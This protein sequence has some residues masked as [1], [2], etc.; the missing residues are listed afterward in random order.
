MD[1]ERF[2]GE[3]LREPTWPEIKSFNFSASIN[4][5]SNYDASN[6]EI[7]WLARIMC[8]YRCFDLYRASHPFRTHS[9]CTCLFNI[10][11]QKFSITAVLF[12]EC[13]NKKNRSAMTHLWFCRFVPYA[14]P[15]LPN[16]TRRTRSPAYMVSWLGLAETKSWTTYIIFSLMGGGGGAG[17]A[18][19]ACGGGGAGGAGV[20]F[21][22]V[23]GFIT[24]SCW[25]GMTFV[26]DGS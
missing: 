20:C 14:H 21:G 12:I 24:I 10:L 5:R 1:W 19:A 15:W 23:A 13:I 16:L 22:D 4:Y 7:K 17:G 25:P 3:S 6:Y 26:T 9:K 2:V 8:I 18:G 11:K